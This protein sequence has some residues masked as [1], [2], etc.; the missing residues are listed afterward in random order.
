[1]VTA[2]LKVPKDKHIRRALQQMRDR[3]RQR[4]RGR[5]EMINKRRMEMEVGGVGVSNGAGVL[6][7]ATLTFIHLQDMNS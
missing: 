4:K 3:E 7:Q 5:H 6:W 1:M 2:P